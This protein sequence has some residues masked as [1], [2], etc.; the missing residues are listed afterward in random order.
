[1][2]SSPEENGCRAGFSLIEI[3]VSMGVIAILISLVVPQLLSARSESQRLLSTS[4]LRQLHAIVIAYATDHDDQYPASYPDTAYPFGPDLM[5]RYPYWQIFRTWPGVVHDYLSL[6]ENREIY[7][8]PGAMKQRIRSSSYETSY[9]YSTSFV[10]R[11]GLWSG[12]LSQ[13]GDEYEVAQ[14]IGAVAFPSSKTI[15]W[16]HEPGFGGKP[17]AWMHEDLAIATPMAM[18]D[19]SVSSRT[20]SEATSPVSNPIVNPVRTQRLHNTRDGVL[21][22]DYP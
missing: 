11:P 10:G 6:H 1:M 16:D 13:A 17:L 5:V 18:A 19:G 14:R 12:R 3:L 20:P 2:V 4:N 9:R 21:G 8:S 15:L 7:L 22:A